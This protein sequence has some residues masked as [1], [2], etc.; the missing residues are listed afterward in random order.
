MKTHFK[1][2]VAE[3]NPDDLL[4]LE[5]AVKKAGVAMSLHPVSDGYDTLSYLKGEG[6]YGDRVTYP[7][8]DI[9]LLDLNMPRVNGFEVLEWVRRQSQCSRL[10]IHVFTASSRDDDVRRAYDLWANS[11]VVKPSRLDELVALVSAL[12]AWHRFVCAP[13]A[14]AHPAEDRTVA[15]LTAGF[16]HSKLEAC[17][18]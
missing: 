16:G 15:G 1:I 12:H 6:L 8:P 17:D 11:Y 2:L 10:I 9:L 5:Q 18:P 3:D 13:R 14:S 4:L 7:W